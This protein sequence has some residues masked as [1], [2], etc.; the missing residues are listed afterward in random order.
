MI[1]LRRL[2][3][4]VVALALGTPALADKFHLSEPDADELR[5]RIIEGVLLEEKDGML[6]IRVEGGEI[7][8]P[9]ASVKKRERDG[10]T[11]AA[12]E[13]REAAAAE[14]L[15]AANSAR[16]AMLADSAAQREMMRRDAAAAEAAMNREDNLPTTVAEAGYYDPIIGRVVASEGL[17]ERE[18]RRGIAGEIRRAAERELR[19]IRRQLRRD[20]RRMR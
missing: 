10:L 1:L 9:S 8:I 16:R 6:R 3:T 12:L 15:A 5:A 18:I 17:I 20:F 4:V 14:A 13:Q 2:S 11:T 7:E 19:D